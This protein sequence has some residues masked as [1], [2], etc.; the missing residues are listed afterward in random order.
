MKRSSNVPLVVLGTLTALQGC[1]SGNGELRNVPRNVTEIRQDF[2]ASQE[3][4]RRDWGNDTSACNSSGN[5]G[6]SG[7]GGGGSGSGSSGSSAEKDAKGGRKYAGPRY[8]WD[9]EI[10]KPVALSPSGET[11]IVGSHSSSSLAQSTHVTSISRGGFGS[12][13]HGF[14]GGG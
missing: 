6:S 1:D 5:S 12:F 13:F 10:G 14:S 8:Y 7:S 4:C 9:R 2:Y 3:D 11:H